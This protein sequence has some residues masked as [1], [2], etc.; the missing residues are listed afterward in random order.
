MKRFLV[1]LAGVAM[2]A[3]PAAFG[4]E[5]PLRLFYSA[6]GLSNPADTNSP[7]QDPTADLGVN[8]VRGVTS[9][10]PVRLWVWAQINPPGS[11]NNVT[12]NGVSFT[13]NL[14]ASGGGAGTISGFQFWN[15]TNGAYGNNTG[16]YQFFSN[17]PAGTTNGVAFAG[18]AVTTGAG[19]N[20]TNTANT[21]D[22]QYRRFATNGTTRID[23]V[24]LGRIDVTPTGPIGSQ[25]QLR[26]AVGT[27]G[28]AQSGDA[29]G[30]NHIYMGWG[31]EASAPLG[32]QF[33]GT[34]PGADATINII[35]EPASLMLL[36]LAGLALRRR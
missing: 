25:V 13:Q 14:T 34:T 4:Q 10:T 11:P 29:D 23:A 26:F 17:S 21:Q 33:G 28:I 22:T 12:Y 27:S 9:G 8:P 1:I 20:N 30:P 3:A 16:R 5:R 18:A 31:D 35:P 7:A 24:L 36:G 15:Y 32:N 6:A 19:V 2:V